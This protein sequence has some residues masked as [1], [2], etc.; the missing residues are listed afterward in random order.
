MRN[1]WT[2][3]KVEKL[4][5]KVKLPDGSHLLGNLVKQEALASSR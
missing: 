3:V 5:R 1:A 2:A 4:I